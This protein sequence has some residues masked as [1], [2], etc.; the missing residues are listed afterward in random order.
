MIIKKLLSISLSRKVLNSKIEKYSKLIS[1]KTLDIGGE[2]ENGVDNWNK[3]KVISAKIE[4]LNID[5]RYNPDYLSTVYDIPVDDN[6]FNCILCFELIEHL[7]FPEK[8]IRE[9]AR[10]LKKDGIG[11]F[12]IPFMYRHH[13]NPRDYQ[14]WSHEKIQKVFYSHSFEIEFFET[15]GGWLIV[16]FDVFINGILGFKIKG[17]VSFLIYLISQAIGKTLILLSPLIMFLDKL[18][19][20]SN[21]HPNYY[22]YT[23]GYFFVV[24]KK[25]SQNFKIR[26]FMKFPKEI[27]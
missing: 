8:A 23:T 27:E 7:E 16:F 22:R 14:R 20:N 6:H 19:L 10:V 13:S 5:K 15:R 2:Q 11:L 26:D 18:I 24:R 25:K 21:I 12:S 17:L 4:T 9:M 3:N 1:G